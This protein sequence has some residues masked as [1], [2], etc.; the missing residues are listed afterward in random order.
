[1]SGELAFNSKIDLWLMVL[2]L[3]VVAA[4]FWG[5]AVIWDADRIILWPVA[6]ILLA[7]ILAPIWAMVSLRYFLSDENLR[8]RCGPFRWQIPIRDITAVSPTNDTKASPAMSFDRL[9][10]DYGDDSRLLISPEPR[11]EFLRQLEYRRKQTV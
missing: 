2:V 4:C 6:V 11:A 5:A 9:Q 8:V 7:G 10:I 3:T 1:M